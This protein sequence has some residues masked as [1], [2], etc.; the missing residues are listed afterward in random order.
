MSYLVLGGI[1]VPIDCFAK[2]DQRYEELLG[3]A[4]ALLRMMDGS[5]FKQ[6]GWNGNKKLK[7]ITTGEGWAPLALTALDFSNPLVLKCANPRSITNAS[8]VISVPAARRSD[9]DYLP[10]GLAIVNQQLVETPLVLIGDTATLT[11]VENATAYR[12]NYWPEINVFINEPPEGW[13]KSSNSHS[14]SFE[15]LEI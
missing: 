13:N 4:S 14:W 2:F 8:N 12:V 10:V 5:L 6:T 1:A 9:A 3:A 7:V 15:A 11:I